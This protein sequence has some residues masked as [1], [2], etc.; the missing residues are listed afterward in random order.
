MKMRFTR[1]TKSRPI[2]IPSDRVSD[3]DPLGMNHFHEM[4]LH[5]LYLSR[6]HL[7]VNACEY[8]ER[9]SAIVDK[10]TPFIDRLML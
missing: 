3:R 9:D 8:G 7:A 10:G 6:K 1:S 4:S 2:L 5:T